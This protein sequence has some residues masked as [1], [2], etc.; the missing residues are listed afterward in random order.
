LSQYTIACYV[1][2]FMSLPAIALP[3][4]LCFEFSLWPNFQH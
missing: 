3:A 4:V 2:I 1:Y